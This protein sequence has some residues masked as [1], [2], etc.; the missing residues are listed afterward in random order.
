MIFAGALVAMAPFSAKDSERAK[1]SP[2]RG[3]STLAFFLAD[4][5]AGDRLLGFGGLTMAT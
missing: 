2:K 1:R 5:A 3:T 4:A